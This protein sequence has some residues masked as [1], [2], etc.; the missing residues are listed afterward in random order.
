MVSENSDILS[1]IIHPQ[2]KDIFSSE[3]NVF[4]SEEETSALKKENVYKNEE[5]ALNTNNSK[6]EKVELNNNL[7]QHDSRVVNFKSPHSQVEISSFQRNFVCD[8][9]LNKLNSLYSLLEHNCIHSTER[10]EKHG[11]CQ[12]NFSDICHF[13]KQKRAD[14]ESRTFQ[15]TVCEKIVSRK[16]TK[17][18]LQCSLCGKTFYQEVKLAIHMR[19]HT[20]KK[21]FQCFVFVGSFGDNRDVKWCMR[22]NLISSRYGVR[23]WMENGIMQV[24]AA[25]RLNVSR[26]VVQG[27][28]DQYEWRCVRNLFERPISS[29]LH[30]F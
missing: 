27:L 28:W 10:Q 6:C 3:F 25:R 7:R 21:P 4:P 14:T 16:G 23:S 18:H 1:E 15:Y 2:T 11:I 17:K 8:I 22:R 9:C 29:T 13:S 30:V 5:Y 12:E 19:T 26:S 20:G 24:D